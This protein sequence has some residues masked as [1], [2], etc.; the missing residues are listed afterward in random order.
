MFT[1]NNKKPEQR[2]WSLLVNF[3]TYFKP[4][5]SVSVGDFEKVNVKVLNFFKV[6]SS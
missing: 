2:H 4:F 6:S 3:E 1:V 5:S